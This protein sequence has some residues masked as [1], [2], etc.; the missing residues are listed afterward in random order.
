MPFKL[1]GSV[2]VIPRG[3]KDLMPGYVSAMMTGRAV[4]R[5]K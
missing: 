2:V 1:E 4:C 5:A 3:E